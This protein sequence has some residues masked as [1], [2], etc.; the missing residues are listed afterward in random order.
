[1]AVDSDPRHT[2]VLVT[3]VLELV[4]PGVGDVVVDATI[5]L[6]G[7]ARLFAEA[8][9]PDGLLVGLDVD[10][11][12][13]R[14]AEQA[15]AG[16]ACRC[17]FKRANFT[18]LAGVLASVG[19]ESVDVLFADLGLSS[20][21]LDDPMRGFSFRHDGPLDMRLDQRLTTQATDLVNRL[22]EDEL[23]DLFYFNAQERLSR[24]IAKRICHAR[25]ENRIRTTQRLSEIVCDAVGVNPNSRKSKIHPATRVF[26]ALRIAVNGELDALDT[27]LR[28]AP[29]LLRSGGRIGVIAFHSLE[30]G[31]V[32][33][34]FRA[35]K[36]AGLYEI[37]TKRPVIADGDER[38]ANPRSRSAKLR[39]AKRLGT[40]TTEAL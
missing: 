30:D 27:L 8:I 32:K 18:D 2:P 25:R 35:R 12:N 26:Q 28:E 3:P 1:M 39:V 37:V 19:A 7:H 6:G 11:G 17:V 5:G 34:D 24:R 13:L 29:P 22:K 33:R 16:V 23:A 14:V 36:S 4:A 38:V 15:L 40:S 10:E 20:A 21:Q 9:G 31:R